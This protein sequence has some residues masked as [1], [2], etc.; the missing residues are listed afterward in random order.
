ML[1]PEPLTKPETRPK[2]FYPF[3]V[4]KIERNVLTILE[5]DGKTSELTLQKVTKEQLQDYEENLDR[6]WVGMSI[7]GRFFTYYHGP[8]TGKWISAT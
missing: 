7:D 8:N 4:V 5:L 2:S 1:V 3:K 6:L